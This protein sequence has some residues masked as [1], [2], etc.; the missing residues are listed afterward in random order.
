MIRDIAVIL[1]LIALTACMIASM[2]TASPDPQSDDR[3]R[4]KDPNEK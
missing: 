1:M 3:E 4:K 2:H